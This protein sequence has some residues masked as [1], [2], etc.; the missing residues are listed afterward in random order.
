M[1]EAVRMR[2]P[3][4]LLPMLAEDEYDALKASIA[5]QG[6][7]PAHPIVVDEAGQILDGHHRK[8]VC[9]ELGIDPPTVTHS[10]LTEAE[11]LDYALS[12][13]LRRRH[14]GHEERVALVRRL[15]TENGW[16]V[17]RIEQATGIPK[18]TVARYLAPVPDGTGNGR[19]QVDE[20]EAERITGKLRAAIDE[21]DKKILLALLRG[22][23][24]AALAGVMLRQFRKAEIELGEEAAGPVRRHWADPR[25]DAI[26]AWPHGG[27]YVEAACEVDDEMKASCLAQRE[28]VA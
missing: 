16:S 27:H 28:P 26:L 11:K 18:S 5:K 22:V 21:M 7:D 24:P 2:A 20:A 12:S 9:D 1:P 25:L 14:L 6:Y 15:S 19:P 13:N 8:M 23:P 4:Q 10:G 3:Y 17:R